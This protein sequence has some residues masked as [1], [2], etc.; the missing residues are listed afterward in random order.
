M[1]LAHFATERTEEVVHKHKPLCCLVQKKHIYI[2]LLTLL[3]TSRCFPLIIIILI[4]RSFFLLSII[5][6]ADLMFNIISLF[7]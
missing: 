2:K 3:L 4:L 7:R 6:H 1:I 5:E